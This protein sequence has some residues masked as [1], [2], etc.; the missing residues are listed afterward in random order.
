MRLPASAVLL[1]QVHTGVHACSARPA[2]ADL[3][4]ALVAGRP[5]SMLWSLARLYIYMYS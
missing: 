5:H 4:K 3:A 2:L 1:S